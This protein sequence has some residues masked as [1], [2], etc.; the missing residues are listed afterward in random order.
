MSPGRA[1][2]ASTTCRLFLPASAFCT[3]VETAAQP[4]PGILWP[5]WPS[6]QVTKLAHHGLPGATPAAARYLST[7]VPVLSPTSWTPLSSSPWAAC[8]AATPRLE[9]PEPAACVGS[10]AAGTE[11]GSAR[12]VR[13]PA[14]AVRPLT[15]RNASVLCAGIAAAADAFGSTA[16]KEAVAGRTGA[17]PAAGGAVPAVEATAPGV[18]A[19]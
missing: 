15:A 1:C 12:N 9:L 3:H 8:S 14:G 6:D 4:V 11:P 18:V 19:G 17:A 10:T 13:G 2:A 16:R 7:S 5:A